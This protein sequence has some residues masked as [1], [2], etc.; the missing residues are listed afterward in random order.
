MGDA[1]GTAAPLYQEMCIRDRLESV[2]ARVLARLGP[3][4]ILINGAGGNQARA[5][6]SKE[7]FEMGDIEADVAT[8]FDMEYKGCLLYTSRCV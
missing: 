7:Y 2:H 1:S 6:T 3:C 8:F 4:D 5:N